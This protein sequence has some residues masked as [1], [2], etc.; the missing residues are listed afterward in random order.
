MTPRATAWIALA[1][2][3]MTAFPV[4]AAKDKSG[5]KKKAD[6]PAAAR[7]ASS[8]G[9]K[10]PAPRDPDLVAGL[11]AYGK[12]D[13][14]SAA[15]S[16][17]TWAAKPG[18]ETDP[19]AAR[20]MYALAYSQRAT[21]APAAAATLQRAE[22]L[23]VARTQ[24]EPTLEAWYYLQGLQQMKGDKPAQ[25]AAISAAFQA[26]DAGQL[27][28]AR[29]GDDWFRVARMSEIA[30]DQEKRSE[31]L[32]RA[33]E[34]YEAAPESGA[35]SP[36]RAMVEKE[37][38]DAA[39][40]S[41]DL[42]AAEKHLAIAARLDPS[43]PDVHRDLGLVQLRRGHLDDALQNWRTTWRLERNNGNGFLYAIPV[44]MKVSAYRAMPGMEPLTG[45]SQFT[46]PALET[47]ATSEARALEALQQEKAAAEAAG[48]P[49]PPEKEAQ[50][51]Q[52]EYRCLQ[53]LLEYVTRGQ[54]LQEFALQNGLLQVIHGKSLPTR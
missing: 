3:C 20:G 12:G 22:P 18:A 51:R 5:R 37:L 49:L 53:Y 9:C 15:T 4:A 50:I 42:E 24:E 34:A 27:C 10:E 44:M 43:I 36:Y 16:L 26:L 48:T 46:V 11:Q 47:N 23:L 40:Q 6:A 29:D 32:H 21:Q 35:A 45:L 54:D 28:A 33:S 17:G 14:A 25:L 30:G 38:G 52:A 8:R 13:W 1:C 31:G 19:A 41:N 7:S 39:L 2:L